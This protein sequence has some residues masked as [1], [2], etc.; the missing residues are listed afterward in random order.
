[1]TD[2]CCG[3]C[4]LWRREDAMDA[5]GR[6]RRDRGARCMWVSTEIYPISIRDYGFGGV[7]PKGSLTS[8]DDGKNCPCWENRDASQ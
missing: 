6:V 5:A 3:T 1:M 4:K 2:K 8:R 7:R